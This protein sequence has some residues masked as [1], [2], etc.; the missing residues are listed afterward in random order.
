MDDKVLVN[1]ERRITLAGLK[2]RPSLML[3]LMDDYVGYCRRH[4][5]EGS[6]L[7]DYKRILSETD[8]LSKYCIG[9]EF[10]SLA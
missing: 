5:I 9:M 8:D 10:S 4:G 2:K 7:D 1:F 6:K 3:R